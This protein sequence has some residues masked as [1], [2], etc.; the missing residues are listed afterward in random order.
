[1]PSYGRWAIAGWVLDDDQGLKGSNK[2]G[3]GHFMV[4]FGGGVVHG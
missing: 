4:T 1:M 2:E 3:P